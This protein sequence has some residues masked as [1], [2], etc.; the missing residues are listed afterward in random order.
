MLIRLIAAVIVSAL[1]AATTFAQ[2]R[3]D[4]GALNSAIE[5]QRQVT[6]AERQMIVSRNLDLTES[7]SIEFWPLYRKYRADVSGLDDRMIRLITDYASKFDTL[8]DDSAIRLLRDSL[9]IDADRSKLMQR[10]VSRFNKIIPGTKVA[11]YMQVESRLDTMMR[12]K[13]QT[14][15][16]LVM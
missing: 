16:P 11:R 5:T 7:E 1:P 15:I 8:D 3:V 13:L 9:K 14:S 4:S 10:Y 12:L 2:D 6:E